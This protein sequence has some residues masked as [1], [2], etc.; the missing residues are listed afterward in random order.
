MSRLSPITHLT[1]HL[2]NS[3]PPALRAKSVNRNLIPRGLKTFRQ[4]D[5][6]RSLFRQFNIEHIFAGVTIKVAML[7]HIRAK[8]RRAAVHIHLPRHPGLHE[9]IQAIVNRCH[10]NFRHPVLGAD[11]YFLC[12]G[13][14]PFLDQHI[15]DVLALRSES[16]AARGELLAQM[17][18]QLFM[19]DSRHSAVKLWLLPVLVKIW[20]NS[21]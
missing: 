3:T 17:F 18:I 16:E 19:F 12:R 1:N 9:R 15:I 4:G 2:F 20:N 6:S 8:T 13:M 14:I 11:E 5:A 7:P 21:K 10:G